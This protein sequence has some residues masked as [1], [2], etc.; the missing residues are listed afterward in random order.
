VSTA[1]RTV[2]LVIRVRDGADAIPAAAKRTV[3]VAEV[4]LAVGAT[5]SRND[6]ERGEGDDEERS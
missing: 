5:Y 3:G 2:G 1:T 4:R 6:N